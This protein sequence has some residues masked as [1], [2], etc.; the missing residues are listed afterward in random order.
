MPD[1]GPI[2]RLALTSTLPD[3]RTNHSI[4]NPSRQV[5]TI[6][7]DSTVSLQEHTAVALTIYYS[8]QLMAA[9]ARARV[10]RQ[11]ADPAGH[12]PVKFKKFPV[13]LRREFA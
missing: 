13:L 4:A 2:G 10:Q 8:A 11:F 9:P 7:D 3:L 6:C 5:A 12:F 1:L